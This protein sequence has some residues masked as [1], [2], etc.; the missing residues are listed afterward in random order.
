MKSK[1]PFGINPF[2]LLVQQIKSV[3]EVLKLK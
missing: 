1:K 3:Q 2:G